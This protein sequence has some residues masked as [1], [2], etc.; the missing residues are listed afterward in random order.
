MTISLARAVPM[1]SPL[2]APATPL[3]DDALERERV[4]VR[5]ARDGDRAAAERLASETYERLFAA[6]CRLAGGPDGAADLVQ[7]TYRKAWQALGDFRAESRFSTWLF[8]IAFTTHLKQQRR[9]RLVVPMA[10]ETEEVVPDPAPDPEDDASRREREEQLR[11]AVALLPD[12]LRFAVT[13][14]YWGDFPVAEIAAAEGVT[15]MGVRKRLARAFRQ[16]VSTL[17]EGS[18]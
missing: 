2:P 17:E 13:A 16:I 12:D 11:R 6:C 5:R 14:R 3:P 8:R 15:P 4:L 1:T 18:R 7:E 10:P 9:P